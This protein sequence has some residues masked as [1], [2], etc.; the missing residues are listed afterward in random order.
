MLE[1]ALFGEGDFGALG[2]REPVTGAQALAVL[3]KDRS[4]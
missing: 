4:V 1:A 3:A 2:T